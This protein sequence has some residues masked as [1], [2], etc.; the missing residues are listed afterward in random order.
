MLNNLLSEQIKDSSKVHTEKVQPEKVDDFSKASV[1]L[2]TKYFHNNTNSK[3]QHTKDNK[4]GKTDPTTSHSIGS[5]NFNSFECY[6]CN[7]VFARQNVL[8]RH[9]QSFHQEFKCDKCC[10]I[11]N[12]QSSYTKHIQNHHQDHLQCTH[13]DCTDTFT[14][15]DA[16]EKH[17]LTIHLESHIQSFECSFR[18]CKKSFP[19]KVLLEMHEYKVHQEFKCEECDIYFRGKN[20]QYK[21]V[22]KL[23]PQGQKNPKG[24][25]KILE[26]KSDQYGCANCS[27]SFSDKDD[28]EKHID[29][30]HKETCDICKIKVLKKN[31]NRHKLTHEDE[32]FISDEEY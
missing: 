3:E 32:D 4:E 24:H 14:R 8:E 28:L 19:R 27:Q 21:H 22:K 11:V 20:S 31:M 30:L 13:A 18:A 16:L 6:A 5:T 1:D 29:Y 26:K 25:K 12:S 9:V 10:E 15:K 7:K 2:E 17:L 23:H